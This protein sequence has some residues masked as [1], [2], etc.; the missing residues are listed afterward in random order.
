MGETPEK[1]YCLA[2]VLLSLAIAAVVLR[3][4]ARRITKISLGWD[5]YMIFLALV[6]DFLERSC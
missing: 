5:D 1:M 4:Y 3:V 2:A 6:G